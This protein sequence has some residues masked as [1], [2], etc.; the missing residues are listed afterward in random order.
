MKL[1]TRRSESDYAILEGL[2]DGNGIVTPEAVVAAARAKDHPWHSRFDWHDKS[3]AHKHRL[4]T[5]REIIRGVHVRIIRD[6]VITYRPAYVSLQEPRTASAYRE[7]SA[8]ADDKEIA[9]QV[10]LNE[11]AR[12][13]GN[14]ERARS[15][16]TTFGMRRDFDELLRGLTEI[17]SKLKLAA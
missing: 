4:D 6:E 3:A 1:M 9:M 14:I 12:I 17:K 5:A 11:V 10:L 16:A 7:T 8:V 2:K 13:G 15:L